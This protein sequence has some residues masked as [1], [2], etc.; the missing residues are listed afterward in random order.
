MPARARMLTIGVILLLFAPVAFVQEKGGQEEYGLYEVVPN[1]PQPLPGA[2]NEAWTWGSTG[3]IYAETPD[4][5]WIGQRGQ[6]PLPPKAKPGDSYGEH[7]GNANRERP[8]TRWT[9]QVIVVNRDGKLVQ[10]WT[11]H[12]PL[13][14]KGGKGPHKIKMSPYDPEKHVWG[15]PGKRCTSGWA[16]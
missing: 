13:L 12:D 2:E 5:I 9:N 8:K 11:Q 6:L 7:M 1:W 16:C 4:R 3:G 14:A 15:R 10:S